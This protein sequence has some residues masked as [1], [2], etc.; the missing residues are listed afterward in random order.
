MYGSTDRYNVLTKISPCLHCGISILSRAKLD[1]VGTLST[2]GRLWKTILVQ[3]SVADSV[4]ILIL[5]AGKGIGA[6]GRR[7]G[8]KVSSQVVLNFMFKMAASVRLWDWICDQSVTR[9][10][11]SVS[12]RY[13]DVNDLGSL[14]QI[15]T[16]PKERTLSYSSSRRM[17]STLAEAIFIFFRVRKSSEP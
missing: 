10:N 15:Q 4:A 11:E 12:L 8:A 2:P 14:I 16:T 7:G 6:G 1:S 13:P 9:V 5:L 3:V 17:V